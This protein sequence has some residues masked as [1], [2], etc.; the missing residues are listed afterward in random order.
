M[1]VYDK[2][3]PEHVAEALSSRGLIDVN[4]TVEA[5]VGVTVHGWDWAPL[6]PGALGRG[7]AGASFAAALTRV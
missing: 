1:A 4:G 3:R 2:G 7:T 5:H 6:V